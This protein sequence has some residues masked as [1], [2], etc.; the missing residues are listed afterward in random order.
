MTHYGIDAGG[1]SIKIGRFEQGVLTEKQT[2]PTD[3]REGGRFILPQIAGRLGPAAGFVLAVPG[4]ILADGRVNGCTNLGW[5]LCDPA[6]EL[7]ALCGISGRCCNDAEAAALGESWQGAARG[8]RSSVTVTLGTGIGGG[9]VIDNKLF[10]GSAGAAGEIG[11]LCMDPREPEP[12]S[13]G[14]HGCLEQY[15]SAT[16]LV[17]LGKQSGLG[18]LN[19]REIAD[20]ARDGEAG[21]LAVFDRACDYLGRGLAMVACTLDPEVFVLAGGLAGAGELLRSKTEAAFQN[22]AFHACRHTKILLSSLGGEAGMYG[23]GKL[24]MDSFT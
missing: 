7:S 16:G 5:G 6:G 14:L 1:T 3:I 13:C 4:P 15:A 17:Q 10:S 20:R 2:L 8:H 22:Y 21:A 19:A 24:A 11:H 23:A 9:I 12:C 18:H